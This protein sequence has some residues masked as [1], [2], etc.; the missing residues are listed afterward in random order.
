M[1]AIRS[2]YALVGG[3]IGIPA[4]FG[5]GLHRLEHFL[6]PVFGKTQAVAHGTQTFEFTM[7][8]VSVG[9]ALVGIFLAWVMYIKSPEL[10]AKFVAKF[11]A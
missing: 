8:G 11:Q 4:A 1:Y 9:I 7:M 6:H 2:Y 5:E 10:P 3:Y